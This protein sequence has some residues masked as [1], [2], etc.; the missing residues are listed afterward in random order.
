MIRCG[1]DT[2]IWSDRR[3]DK[4]M[5]SNNK[6]CLLSASLVCADLL[7]LRSEILLLE[8]GGA[9]YIHFDVMDGS[10]VPRLGLLP[11]MLK[12][13]KAATKIPTDIHLMINNP[14][15]YIS[16][17]AAAGADII[18]IHAESTNHIDHAARLI[19]KL[20][21]KAGI[22]LNPGTSLRALDYLVDDIDLVMLMA[23]NP[24]IVGHRIIEK[25]FNK[26]AHLKTMLADRPEM[27]I[28]IDGGVTFET[29]PKIIAAGAN[30]LV[31]G[32]GTIFRSHE[33]TIDNKLSALRATI[34]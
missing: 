18:T 17:F 32:N 12:A 3:T 21:L 7:N 6:K 24:G 34:G 5:T 26:I 31:C 16:D 28:E 19:K 29:A 20:G 15:K 25:V 9:D 8:K 1:Q 2:L 13:V 10:F 30:M 11:E 27:L 33:D 22:A 14:E 23:I 4:N